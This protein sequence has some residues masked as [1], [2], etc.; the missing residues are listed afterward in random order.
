MFVYKKT[1]FEINSEIK[2]N[3][4]EQSEE[5]KRKLYVIENHQNIYKN[6]ICFCIHESKL[7]EHTRNV[8]IN[9]LCDNLKHF[10]NYFNQL[11]VSHEK[12]NCIYFFINQLIER[13]INIV[14]FYEIIKI[15]ITKINDKKTVVNYKILH[16]KILFDE[17]NEKIQN[18]KLCV[19]WLLQ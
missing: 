7:I 14:T 18:P 16:D 6:I 4:N 13:D 1:I 11:Y 15:F 9:N 12:M 17:W 19:T 5:E 3:L 2:K 8:H 10:S